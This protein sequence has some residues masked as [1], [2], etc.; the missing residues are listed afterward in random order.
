MG[1]ILN[2]VRDFVGVDDDDS[3]KIGSYGQY[4]ATLGDGSNPDPATNH[5]D[6]DPDPGVVDISY[7]KADILK[8]VSEYMA[9]DASIQ[10]DLDKMIARPAKSDEDIAFDF[11]ALALKNKK[12]LRESIVELIDKDKDVQKIVDELATPPKP[13]DPPKPV[14]PPK[15]ANPAPTTDD[16]R[17]MPVPLFSSS[18]LPFDLDR[19]TDEVFEVMRVHPS[20]RAIILDP[21]TA[22]K[23]KPRPKPVYFDRFNDP[24][25]R[26]ELAPGQV[27]KIVYGIFGGNLEEACDK[28]LDVEMRTAYSNGDPTNELFPEEGPKKPSK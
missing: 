26:K 18:L 25:H 4:D 15:P 19:W 3:G 8:I 27:D 1:R 2:R 5:P 13:A 12:I 16:T 23:T 11:K 28:Y 20:A 24:K 14:D 10:G 6:P 9:K 22:E 21:E 7:K 17:L